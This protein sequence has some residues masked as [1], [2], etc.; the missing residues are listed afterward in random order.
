MMRSSHL[1]MRSVFHCNR[2]TCHV[3]RAKA[4]TGIRTR[5]MSP[6]PWR[7]PPV[8]TRVE[9]LSRMEWKDGSSAGWGRCWFGRGGV[10][11]KGCRR[12]RAASAALFWHVVG[13][14]RKVC[15][16]CRVGEGLGSR[17]KAF[18]LVGRGINAFPV[19]VN[20]LVR[21]FEGRDF[22]PLLRSPFPIS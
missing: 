17:V 14:A 13:L 5:M 4:V 15:R 16:A 1:A 21:R 11:E 18:I 22:S 6:G 3:P 10:W 19:E 20:G 7:L 2:K 9:G 8:R 12:G